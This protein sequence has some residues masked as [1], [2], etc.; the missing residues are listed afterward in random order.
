MSEAR[1]TP[2]AARSTLLR[3]ISFDASLESRA[4]RALADLDLVGCRRAL[5]RLVDS[6]ELNG[7][8][9]REVA[10]LL[11]DILQRINRWI[12]RAPGDRAACDRYRAMLVEMFARVDDPKQARLDFLGALDALLSF[13]PGATPQGSM[14]ERAQ[15]FI[16]ENYHRR[17][18]LSTVASRLNV[19]PNYLSRIFKRTTGVNLTTY[20]HHVRLKHAMTL[21]GAGERSISEIAYLVGYQN[22]RDFYRNFVKLKHASPREVQRELNHSGGLDAGPSSG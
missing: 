15:A 17:I 22:Y 1:L 19:S 4:F 11:L 21:L 18:S 3:R 16:R 5:G 7:G 14:V 13:H 2:E 20:L 9:G 8:G 12:H 10:L 6:L